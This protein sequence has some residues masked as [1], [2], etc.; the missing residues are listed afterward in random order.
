MAVVTPWHGTPRIPRRFA[1]A[2]GEQRL[3][4][5]GCS[6]E[7]GALSFEARC[8]R[9]RRTTAGDNGTVSLTSFE[10][11]IWP[12]PLRVPRRGQVTRLPILNEPRSMGRRESRRRKGKSA[13]N[14]PVIIFAGASVSG[15]RNGNLAPRRA[16]TITKAAS[17]AAPTLQCDVAIPTG[18]SPCGQGAPGADEAPTDFRGTLLC[19]KPGHWSPRTRDR[20]GRPVCFQIST[21]S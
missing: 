10:G 19:L 16:S 20:Q 6:F 17:T 14:R 11:L 12:I 5:G 9:K 7:Q 15:P 1:N 3:D 8:S 4:V 2:V 13:T 21:R 18:N